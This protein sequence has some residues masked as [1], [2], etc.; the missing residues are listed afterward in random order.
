MV[1][2]IIVNYNTT[3]LTNDCIESV[4]LHSKGVDFEVIIVDNSDRDD[5]KLF[6]PRSQI[7]IIRSTENI[8]FGRANN[9]GLNLATGEYILLLNSDTI[10]LN[11]IL[12]YFLNEIL[13]TSENVFG[14]STFLVNENNEIIHS[15]AKF[16]TVLSDLFERVK[17]KIGLIK[18]SKNLNYTNIYLNCYATGAVLFL[19]K[20]VISQVGF[21]DP[22]FFL[23]YEETDL[24]KRFQNAGYKLKLVPGP[25]II[26]KGSVSSNKLGLNRLS[27]IRYESKLIYFQKWESKLILVLYRVTSSLLFKIL[28]YSCPK[29]RKY[30]IDKRNIL[31]KHFGKS[32]I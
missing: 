16:P 27:L 22:K 3:Q 9:L 25:K 7:K 13:E 29:K 14:L 23:Y 30:Y 20:E 17:S 10:V 15:I 32:I 6:N 1:S 2:I 28:E 12:R 31:K 21:F 5:F 8:G 18:F 4:F 19:K 11:N 26:H 24:Q